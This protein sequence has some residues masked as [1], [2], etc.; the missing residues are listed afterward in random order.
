MT[1]NNTTHKQ[2]NTD[3]ARE[4]MWQAAERMRW[5][6][7]RVS[8]YVSEQNRKSEQRDLDIRTM[9]ADLRG[10]SGLCADEAWERVEE[11]F[12]QM[13]DHD[14]YAEDHETDESIEELQLFYL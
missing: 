1:F 9:Y 8:A 12:G 2:R 5:E 3:M 6:N 7:V 14:I 11:S 13:A 4:Q 10:N